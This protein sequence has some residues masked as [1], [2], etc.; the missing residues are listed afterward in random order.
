TQLPGQATPAQI[1]FAQITFVY[2][3][4]ATEQRSLGYIN[5]GA[6][7]QAHRL[8]A[9]QSE[10]EGAQVRYYALS[11][12]ASSAGSGQDTL[13]QVQECRDST[14]AVCAAPTTF[15]WS[16]GTYEFATKEYP[17]NLVFGDITQW[18]GFKQGDIDG[19]G[20]QD[21]VFIKEGNGSAVCSSEFILTAFSIID[22]MGR[23]AYEMGP[24][25]CT[26]PNGSVG[27]DQRGDGGW[28]LV[29]Y[30]GDGRDDLFISS[31]LGPG[32]RLFLSTGRGTAK[33]FDDTQNQIA[34]LTPAVPS[35]DV[36]NQQPQ[37]A[38]LN[39][40]GL[41]DVVYANAGDNPVA[42]I[43]E[44]SGGTYVWGAERSIV[45]DVPLSSLP[46][47]ADPRCSDPA[48]DCGRALLPSNKG[49]FVQLAD[50]N[51]DAA[52]D[53]LM[54]VRD[55]VSWENTCDC[56]GPNCQQQA[57]T[58]AQPYEI[59]EEFVSGGI[60]STQSCTG[61]GIDIVVTTHAM[62]VKSIAPTS[63]TLSLSPTL[64]TAGT[65]GL[66]S[67]NYA[68]ANGDGLTDVFY[69]ASSG[70]DWSYRINTGAGL[71]APTNLGIVDFKELTR[72]LDINGD[73][74]ADVLYV[75]NPGTYKAYNVRYALPAGGFGP[76]TWIPGVAGSNG[77]A[78][79]CEGFACDSNLK[80]P[81]F[82]DFD[83]DGNLDF[84]SLKLANSPDLFVSRANTRYVPR[85][86]ITKFTNGFGAETVITYS[87]LTLKD[88]YRPDT[89][90]RNTANWGR[91]APVQDVLGPLYAVQQ[92]SSSSPQNGDTATKST[93]HYRY[94]GAKLQGGGRGLLGVREI[95]TID[96]NQ[97]GG[98]VVTNT[99]YAQNFPFVGV[100][101]QTSKFANVNLVFVAP[102]CLT[103]TP[104]ETCFSPRGQAG[105]S[106]S[107]TGFSFSTQLW[108]AVLD[109]G[110]A[111]ATFGQTSIGPALPLTIG[112]EEVAADPI[113][114]AQTS[115]VTTAFNYGSFGNVAS[116]SVD[117]YAGTSTTP[118]STVLTSN[119]YSDDA[120]RWRLGRLTTSTVTHKRPGMPDVVRST[121]FAY[122]M[123]GSVTGLLTEE[124][125]QPNGDV[126][127]DMRKVHT[128]DDYGNR[129]FSAVC[130]KQ[131]TDCRST[132][133]QYSM[134]DWERIHRY[135]R[136]VYDARG[137]YPTQTVELFRPGTATDINTQPVEVV[138]SEVLA[139][140]VYG[141]VTESVNLN[142]VR[143]VARYGTLGRAYYA[144][145]QTD[146]TNTIPNA[147]GTVGAST[148]TT[149]RWCNTGNGAVTCPARARFRSKIVTTASPTGWVYYDVLGR[150]VLKVA[151]TFNAGVS[152]KDAT[153]VCT[154]YDAVG[155]AHRV[156][157]PFF[158]PGTTASGEPDVA[159][160]CTDAARKWVKTEFD[161]LGRPVK[162][163]EA[164]NAVSTVAYSG[165]TVTKTN[166]RNNITVEVKNA[167][168]EL[169][170]A[171]DAVGLST[172]Y[173]YDAAGNLG[174][175]SRDAGRGAITSSM[176]Y[177]A[178]A[179]KTYMND[180]DAGVRHLGY[181][182]LGE[183]L[184]EHDGI[185][186]GHQQRYDFRGR[187][188]WR[189]V[190][191]NPTPTTSA[192]EHSSTSHFDTAVN[193]VGQENC[194]VADGFAYAGWQGQSDK[195][196]N[197]S[198]C[199]TYDTMGRATASATS[200]DGV[201]YAGAVIYDN[202]GRAQRS[203]DPSGKWLKTEYSTR[204]HAVRLCESSASDASV[205][206]ASGVATTYLETQ[207]T[208]MFGNVAKDKRGGVNAMQ[209]WRA[210]DPLTG[211]ASEI[212]VGA[213]NV[214]CQLMRDR[215]VWDN[216]GNLNWRDRKDYGED[217]WYDSADRF[218]ISRVNRIGTTT[219]GYGAGTVTDW[220]TYDKLGNICARLMRGSDAT[221]MNYNG[222]AGC[223][224][225]GADGTIVNTS[226]TLS[227]HQV[228]QSNS[229][230]DYIY[231]SHGN[232]TF[233][234]SSTSDSLDRT[235]RYTAD[236]KAYEIFKGPA[237]AP[238]RMARFWYD[239]AGNRYKREDTG[240]GITGTRRTLYVGNL[241]IVSENG[242][243]TYKRYIG[244]VLVQNVVNGIAANRYT[245]ADHL[246]SI[247]A[248][249]NETGA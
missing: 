185:Y 53:L 201:S 161:L 39:G 205:T 239:P 85:D 111:F 48:Y 123:T 76:G 164:N 217:F 96:P 26:T 52:S 149:F 82:G 139:R 108:T 42:R 144:W 179:R 215:Y 233:A 234:D 148:L 235:I 246:G 130:T 27:I 134:W 65:A 93:L 125:I 19:D 78:L 230:S 132:N 199:N 238:N 67:V 197:W 49:G 178:L 5:G 119:T 79:V 236:D 89:G 224:L 227:P 203:Q 212:C 213:D 220:V 223:G 136:Q 141:N 1:P 115:R 56:T 184:V 122:Q 33:V 121:S 51:G 94:N 208:D 245:F 99:Q 103:A 244:G 194:T 92:V 158:V 112:S 50:F 170:Q 172:F 174:A 54:N 75:I 86:V 113:T 169:A 157:M 69:R 226:Q 202:L 62:T 248:V 153:G 101:T 110:T 118:M 206:C 95:A 105:T 18:R 129:I 159:A 34:A 211:R 198:R 4:R 242:T 104:T 189:G 219:Y 232:Q 37:L 71:S 38:D 133:I 58:P 9:I 46:P 154:E 146:Q 221:W 47:A 145:Q 24:S 43:M 68:D 83:G 150:E 156:S 16:P 29:D 59:G 137:R 41:T 237:A 249:A 72:F 176:G 17:S 131:V 107:G 84:M 171:T 229:Y 80:A 127:Q 36:A 61:A 124:R 14:L 64:G 207:E 23:P 10:A 192:W 195:V 6:V 70:S 15:A 186:G 73:G 240:T 8:T 100:P 143:S 147:S 166:A 13:T 225:N 12:V 168:G 140:D 2:A 126:F 97:T 98:Y 155:R 91:G 152:G 193:G 60:A 28:Q 87:P 21:L 180:P 243:T 135:G 209:T 218:N 81:M 88:F 182:A 32:W 181:N 187:V 74:R 175:V 63:V 196:Q 7:R 163:T 102:A 20:R 231:D 210:Y 35:S 106:L 44:R 241:E 191:F 247:V 151:Q 109:Q 31:P 188:Q 128:L 66:N 200:I 22:S 120:V 173:A 114:T 162:V 183:L 228:R 216:V 222:R 165:L 177:D 90:T 204:G 190:W 77:N 117:T 214:S 57:I 167:L 116:S 45:L 25:Q 55:I 160:V 11:Y 142:N 138:T 3:L 40:D 30:N